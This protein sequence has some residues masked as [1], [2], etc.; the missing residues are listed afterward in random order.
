MIQTDIAVFNHQQVVPLRQAAVRKV[1]SFLLKGLPHRAGQLCIMFV[2]NNTIR[3]W[4]RQYKGSNEPTDVLAFSL[5]IDEPILSASSEAVL[6]D[7][8]ISAEKA[9]QNAMLYH[10]DVNAE[11]VLYVIHGILHLFGLRDDTAVARKKMRAAEKKW[12]HEILQ[13]PAMRIVK[14]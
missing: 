3:V 12:L 7:I 11:L 5:P 9:K 8:V 4:N 1:V 10:Q 6:G 13:Y 14:G 2:D